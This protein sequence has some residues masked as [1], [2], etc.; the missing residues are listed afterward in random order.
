M[1]TPFSIPLRLTPTDPAWT[2][3]GVVP[4]TAGLPL[5]R[6]RFVNPP[7]LYLRDG[8]ERRFR[9]DSSVSERWPDGSV[10][11]L[12][13]DTQVHVSP[14]KEAVQLWLEADE[15]QPAQEPGLTVSSTA[16]SVTIDTGTLTVQLSRDCS[17]L[18]SK[19][20]AM[21]RVVIEDARLSIFGAD[22]APFAVAWDALTVD[23]SNTLRAQVSGHGVATGPNGDTLATSLRLEFYAGLGL[24]RAKLTTRNP[25]P[26]AHP[27]GIW[28]LGDAGSVLLR[29]VTYELAVP[30]SMQGTVAWSL[31]P[32]HIERARTSVRLYQDSSGGDY[33][34]STN[35]LARDGRVSTMIRGFRAE[36]DGEESF[37][38]RALPTVHVNLGET[39]LGV[40]LPAFWQ[41]F[42]QALVATPHGIRVSFFPRESS[43]LHELQGGEQKTHECFLL[44]GSPDA[45]HEASLQ[46]CHA[47]PV[48]HATSDWYAE[49]QVLP[50]FVTATLDDSTY[51]A[52][53]NAAIQGTDTFFHKREAADEY[54]W[55]HF[56]DIYGDHEAVF[57]KGPTPLMSHYNNQ[58]DPVGGFLYQFMRTG[59]TRWWTQ[60]LELA[61]H[62]IDI[63]TYHTDRDKAAYN[64]G[65]FWHTYH[66][67]DAGKANHRTYPK[68]TNGGGP[69][70]EQNYTTGLMLHHLITGD[71]ASRD[72][73]LALAQFVIDMDD[74]TKTVFRWL[75][76]GNTGIAS[77]SRTPDYQG[78]GRGSANSLN[79]LLDGHRMSGDRKYLEKA[80]QI[81]R[82]VTHPL[83][84]IERLALLD[85][86]NRWFYTM[87]L[88]SLAKYLEYKAEIGE[89]D[90]MYAYSRDVLLH[91]ARWMAAHERPYLDRPDLLEYPTETWPAQDIRKS[92][93][94]DAAARYVD[95]AE[96]ATFLERAEFFFS[97][98]TQTLSAM[99]TRTLARPVVLLMAHGW[100]RAYARHHGVNDAPQT[101]ARWEEQWPEP[102][103][104]VPQRARAIRRAKMLTATVAVI[105]TA[106][107]AILAWQLIS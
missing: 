1:T 54:G 99:P 27:G 11:W 103:V 7:C 97:Y 92:E 18:I 37:G 4:L 67:V 81:I 107:A 59:D 12:L 57:H 13:L 14:G 74:G 8:S 76:G 88:Q 3:S 46:S 101:H 9:V 73:A 29:E 69:S 80:E 30:A 93:I 43:Q 51:R 40:A 28:E 22:S 49:A 41:N 24:V 48:L 39:A 84:D 60:C 45:T 16:S 31:G 42:P 75:D 55:R 63:D 61:Q 10:R 5:P 70:S 85:P 50:H 106:T 36:A 56:G 86:E 66:Y 44:L 98:C 23:V 96:R 89:L 82:R 15:S 91:F 87:Y 58:Y 90:A 53:V 34:N 47:K 72:T 104:F 21:G 68:G 83:Q 65:L 32:D 33:W 102:E 62:V 25:R 100:R 105:G 94:L 20:V 77:A 52:L 95:G 79:A 38:D 26:A 71:A 64:H 35:H 2:L 19:G 6:G 17:G 78:P